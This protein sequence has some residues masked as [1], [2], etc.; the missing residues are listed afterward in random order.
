MPNRKKKRLR[1]WEDIPEMGF[2]TSDE[3]AEVTGYR[4]GTIRKKAKND[5]TFPEAHERTGWNDPLRFAK[6]DIN[7]YLAAREK[8]KA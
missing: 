4:V 2:A 6:S 1:R 5:P 8:K 3:V 7:R